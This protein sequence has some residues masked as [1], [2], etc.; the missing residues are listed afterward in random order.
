MMQRQPEKMEEQLLSEQ[1]RAGNR[2]A[3]HALYETYA[4]RL[5]ALCLRY[6]GSRAEA[7]DLVH[8]AFLKIFASFDRFTWRG[9]GSLR[10]WVERLTINLAIER[11]RAGSRLT[12]Q[13]LDERIGHLPEPAAEE[14]DRIPQEELL[15]LIGQLPEGYRTIL[16]LYCLDGFSHREIARMLGINEKSSSSQLTRARALLAARVRDY[17]ND[18]R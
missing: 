10:A 4:G 13:P 11:L 15:R 16:N 1:C 12:V 17:I 14:I 2:T 8:D 9:K 6:V 3:W 5:L 7:E 18:Q